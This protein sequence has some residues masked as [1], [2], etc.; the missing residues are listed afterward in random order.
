MSGIN[1]LTDSTRWATVTHG[2]G[3][4]GLTVTVP[5]PSSTPMTT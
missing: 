2:E 5:E 1:T 3:P 4:Q